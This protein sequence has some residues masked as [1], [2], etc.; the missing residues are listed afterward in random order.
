MTQVLR[1]SLYGF[2]ILREKDCGDPHCQDQARKVMNSWIQ[3]LEWDRIPMGAGIVLP[4]PGKHRWSR[5]TRGHRKKCHNDKEKV[6]EQETC[7][8][9]LSLEDLRYLVDLTN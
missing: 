1:A 3:R 6:P 8:E 7:A 5:T 4:L 9:P 2:S